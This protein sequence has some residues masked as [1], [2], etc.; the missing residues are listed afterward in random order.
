MFL[1][2]I[3]SPSTQHCLVKR[4]QRGWSAM[5]VYTPA[6]L[7]GSPIDACWLGASFARMLMDWTGSCAILGHFVKAVKFIDIQWAGRQSG[8][9]ACFVVL[10]ESRYPVSQQER[11]LRGESITITYPLV[12]L[13]HSNLSKLNR[14]PWI[15]H[16]IKCSIYTEPIDWL[17]LAP[18]CLQS[19][20]LGLAFVSIVQYYLKCWILRGYMLIL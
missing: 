2:I 3:S 7:P 1:W 15:I 19:R 14:T 12:I 11:S 5:M 6:P 17:L 18:V 20:T 13:F 10:I 9:R 16:N 4:W 8:D